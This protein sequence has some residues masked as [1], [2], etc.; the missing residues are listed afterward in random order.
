M[1]AGRTGSRAGMFRVGSVEREMEPVTHEAVRCSGPV[2]PEKVE[3]GIAENLLPAV[4]DGLALGI[5][6]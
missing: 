6:R 4:I 5:A 2:A 3:P 1:M